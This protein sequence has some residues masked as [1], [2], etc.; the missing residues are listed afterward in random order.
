M[1]LINQKRFVTCVSEFVGVLIC[2][3]KYLQLLTF[4]SLF[5]DMIYCQF[6]GIGICAHNQILNEP[7][8]L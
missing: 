7:D 3:P 8:I 5:R 6:L 1:Y 2:H 4:L